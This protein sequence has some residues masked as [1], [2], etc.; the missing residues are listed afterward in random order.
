MRKGVSERKRRT[1]RSN[2]TSTPL[3]PRLSTHLLGSRP[4]TS[5]FDNAQL[6]NGDLTKWNVGSAENCG[7]MFN[8][9]VSFNR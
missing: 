8:A 7:W 2:P 4:A 5:T 9:A 1:E 3:D 6:F